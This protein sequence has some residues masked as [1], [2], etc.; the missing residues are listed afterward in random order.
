MTTP[1]FATVEHWLDQGLYLQVH[2]HLDRLAAS[3]LPGERLQAVRALRY[4]G[5]DRAGEAL[6]VRTGRRFAH[7]GAAV[8]ARCRGA[9]PTW[10]AS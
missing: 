2:P 1:D 9:G 8:A 4:L 10:P 3:S 6:L 7:D 5:A